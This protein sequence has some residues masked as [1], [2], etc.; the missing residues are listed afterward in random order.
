MFS[1][2][3]ESLVSGTTDNVS[4]VQN[5]MNTLMSEIIFIYEYNML[6]RSRNPASPPSPPPISR[7]PAIADAITT[8]PHT[9]I[10]NVYRANPPMHLHPSETRY[11][12]L[13]GR[14]C[15]PT[16]PKNRLRDGYKIAAKISMT[17]TATR[18]KTKF[19]KKVDV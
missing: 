15:R 13:T 3:D 2:Y 17:V 1:I 14:H 12:A 16:P 10:R 6:V 5:V 4:C 9:Y 18:T 11:R 7:Y 19:V 8:P